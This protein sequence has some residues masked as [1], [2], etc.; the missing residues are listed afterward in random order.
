MASTAVPRR[1]TVWPTCRDEM[2]LPVDET[3]ET[4]TASFWP[5]MPPL[6]LLFENPSP[7]PQPPNATAPTIPAIEIRVMYLERTKRSRI[8]EI[9][10]LRGNDS[11]PHPGLRPSRSQTKRDRWSPIHRPEVILSASTQ[12]ALNHLI[13][14]GVRQHRLFRQGRYRFLVAFRDSMN[15]VLNLPGPR[16]FDV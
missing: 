7:P 9:P 11:A 14:K 4:P 6:L 15:R 3:M 13:E 1:T 12:P 10:F 16:L 2:L 8:R 5:G